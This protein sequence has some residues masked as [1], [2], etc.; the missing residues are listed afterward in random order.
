MVRLSLPGQGRSCSAAPISIWN[1]A[2]SAALLAG[3]RHPAGGAAH[4]RRREFRFSGRPRGPRYVG[5]SRCIAWRCPASSPS[6]FRCGWKRLGGGGLGAGVAG[7]GL[8]RRTARYSLAAEIVWVGGGLVLAA[9]WFS[10]F[11]PASADLQLGCSTASAFPCAGFCATAQIL[12]RKADDAGAGAG[13]G[14]RQPSG[15]LIGRHGNRSLYQVG[16]SDGGADFLEGRHMTIAFAVLGAALLY[17]QRCG[18]ATLSG[19][20]RFTAGCLLASAGRLHRLQPAI[21]RLIPRRRRRS[22]IG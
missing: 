3:D 16:I 9:L 4:D 5:A 11:R 15:L 18:R 17:R 19:W 12:K 10:T 13:A 20:P 8:R 7:D 21:R 6:P 22:S 2:E 1:E 14:A